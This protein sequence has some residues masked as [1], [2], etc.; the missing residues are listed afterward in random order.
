MEIKGMTS[1]IIQRTRGFE[2]N[3]TINFFL[4]IVD[5]FGSEHVLY[6]YM[7][8]YKYRTNRNLCTNG[9]R[10]IPTT[11]RQSFLIE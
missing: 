5:S 8:D 1:Q 10:F 11:K 3:T 2:R 4:D 9:V 6:K 7:S